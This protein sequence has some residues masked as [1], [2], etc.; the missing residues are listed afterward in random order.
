MPAADSGVA[1][2]RAGRAGSYSARRRWLSPPPR[3]WPGRAAGR[4]GPA[5]RAAYGRPTIAAT[6]SPG[7]RLEHVANAADGVDQRLAAG[8]DLLAQVADVQLDD[9]RLA[10]EVVVP[11][12]VEDLGL[13]QHAARVAHQEAEQLE[14]GS[15]QL[16]ELAAPAHLP[17]ILLHRQ[18]AHGQLSVAVPAGDPGAAQQPAQPG[19]H[20]LQA[21]GL[22]D[23]VVTAGRDAGDSVLN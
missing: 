2:S 22:G 14:L 5:A 8:V 10:A 17:G 7:R 15:R 3:S 23:V 13:G 6:W 20:L 9:V 19:K 4:R 1:G 16:D 12:P 11:D 18:V 21:E